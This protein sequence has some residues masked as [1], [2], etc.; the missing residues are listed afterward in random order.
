MAISAEGVGTWVEAVLNGTVPGVAPAGLPL[1]PTRD[2]ARPL[3]EADTLPST[4]GLVGAAWPGAVPAL[5]AAAPGP[6]GWPAQEGG[7]PPGAGVACPGVAVAPPAGEPGIVV[8]AAPGGPAGPPRKPGVAGEPGVPGAAPGPP[9]S[10]PDW[11]GGSAG[12]GTRGPGI[13]GPGVRPGPPGPPP[14]GGGPPPLPA[15]GTDGPARNEGPL[16]NRSEVS[17]EAS[18]RSPGGKL[19]PNGK[20]L[21]GNPGG[22]IGGD[23]VAPADRW[24]WRPAPPRRSCERRY[25]LG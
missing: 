17:V 9:G 18:E 3:I 2:W 6:P 25:T 23:T 19:F 14:Q 13:S 1:P 12:P 8:G 10:T 5:V 7:P 4:P 24:R 20:P 11:P 22:E 16:R 15:G 21:P